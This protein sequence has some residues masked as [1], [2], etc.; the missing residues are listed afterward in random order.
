MA[1]NTSVISVGYVG[2]NL[3]SAT[4]LGAGTYSLNKRS[5]VPFVSLV[6]SAGYKKTISW[7]ELVDV[8]NG[9][10]VTVRN[11][12]FH[13]GDIYLNKGRD[14]CNR[15]SRISVPVPYTIQYLAEPDI[16]GEAPGIFGCEFPCDTRTA[17]RAYLNI[18]ATMVV[19][20]ENQLSFFVRGRRLD[21]S[22]KTANSLAFMS[23]PY[24]PGVGFLSALVYSSGMRLSYIPLGEGC[25]ASADERPHML[26]DAG[27]V[28]I[29]FGMVTPPIN[30]FDY[31][32]W[33][34]DWE[35]PG[36]PLTDFTRVPG[37]WYIVE[38][39]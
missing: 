19:R 8:P 20:M 21:A 18:D 13:G 11:A 10:L 4:K 38:Y 23:P 2:P 31:V 22:M 36:F 35:V 27:D 25:I 17:K 33:P 32:R 39:D 15:P 12:S 24:G 34:A 16:N 28:F 29:S 3:D 37:T 6:G 7:G 14:M 30:L 26:L 9:Q 1:D 5:N